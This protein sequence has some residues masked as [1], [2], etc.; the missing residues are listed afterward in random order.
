MVNKYFP[1]N[2]NIVTEQ[3][4]N[5]FD[6][7][8]V[9]PDTLIGLGNDLIYG[10]S[11]CFECT[12]K[13]LS[14]AKA[15]YEEWHLGYPN[16]SSIMYNEFIEAN[17]DIE[18]GYTKY[19]DSLGQI[20]MASCELVGD[21]F[22]LLP[23]QIQLDMIELANKIRTARILFQEDSTKVPNWDQLRIDVQKLQNKLNKIIK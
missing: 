8:W 13:H 16:H 6:I 14:R 4:V 10:L 9:K 12:K 20:D 17:K 15:L 18:E 23:N 1:V 5:D 21:N 22:G 3:N 7:M 11:N 2:N 19:W